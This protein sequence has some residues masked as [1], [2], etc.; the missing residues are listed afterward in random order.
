MVGVC[1]PAFHL[2]KVFISLPYGCMNLVNQLQFVQLYPFISVTLFGFLKSID[3]DIIY[4]PLAFNVYQSI[5]W[6]QL[7]YQ[8]FE[9]MLSKEFNYTLSTNSNISSVFKNCCCLFLE[10]I[11]NTK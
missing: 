10:K 3:Y 8:T 1:V 5:I 4:E 2:Y 9:N 11:F 7:L 6:H